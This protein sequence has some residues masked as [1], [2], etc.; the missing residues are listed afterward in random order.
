MASVC[1]GVVHL[2]SSCSKVPATSCAV[3]IELACVCIFNFLRIVMAFDWPK[4]TL[5]SANSATRSSGE[6]VHVLKVLP[7]M[8]CV[9]ATVERSCQILALPT[10]CRNSATSFEVKE[11]NKSKGP[12]LPV[13][14]LTAG[15]TPVATVPV[16]M[17]VRC[18]GSKKLLCS[19]GC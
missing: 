16:L 11:S 9:R 4:A 10:F 6:V 2:A 5:C 14:I 3:N 12:K 1:C 18:A 13:F 17:Q 19:L 15:A 8:S 7:S